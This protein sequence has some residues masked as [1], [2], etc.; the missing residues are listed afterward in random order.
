MGEI[1]RENPG[2]YSCTY[3]NQDATLLPFHDLIKGQAAYT[4]LTLRKTLIIS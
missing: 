3:V 1:K 2:N 4:Q